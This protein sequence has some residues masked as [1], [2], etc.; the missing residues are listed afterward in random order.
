[1]WS[2]NESARRAFAVFAS[3]ALLKAEFRKHS[4]MFRALVIESRQLKAELRT[5]KPIKKD[6]ESHASRNLTN[7]LHRIWLTKEPC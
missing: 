5:L 3:A 1:M 7:P 2:E 6:Q 4:A